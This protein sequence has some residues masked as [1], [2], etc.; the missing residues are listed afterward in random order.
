VDEFIR[1]VEP[2][3]CDAARDGVL[4]RNRPCIG[5]CPVIRIETPAGEF[6]IGSHF[7]LNRVSRGLRDA[8]AIAGERR[9]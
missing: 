1:I 4:R 8:G 2:L 5:A 7:P 9:R 6:V 3:S